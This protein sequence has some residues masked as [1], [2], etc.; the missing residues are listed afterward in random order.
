MK[1]QQFL[2]LLALVSLAGACDFYDD[3]L[4]IKN[5]SN[6]AIAFDYSLDTTLEKKPMNEIPYFVREKILPGETKSQSIFGSTQGWPFL[7][8]R[9]NN[10]K[11]NVFIISIDTLL[12][13]DDWEYIRTHRLYQ[14]YS[15]TEEELNRINWIVEYP[16]QKDG[17]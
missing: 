9:S 5:N 16:Q 13:Y 15:F 2:I 6:H 12:K 17:D 8:Q 3:R 14:R 10:N 1:L 7:I 4:N 11:L